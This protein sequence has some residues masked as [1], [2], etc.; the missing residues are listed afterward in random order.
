MELKIESRTGKME[1][2][3][4]RIYSFLS[5]FRNFSQMIPA[6]K[7]KNW[8]ATEDTCSFSVD[9]LGNTGLRIVEKEPYKLVKITGQEGA[10]FDFAFYIQLKSIDVL[11]TRI[12][13]TIQADV[14][15]MIKM[16]AEKPLQ[17][18][19]DGLIDQLEKIRM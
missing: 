3:D 19:L 17:K 15:P 12:K 11:D 10:P 2:A 16:M 7:V 9:G 5:D 13:L 8:T 14:N 1:N 18:F 6:D 4:S